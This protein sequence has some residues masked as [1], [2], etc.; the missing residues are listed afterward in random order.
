MIVLSL[1]LQ[2]SEGE[3]VTEKQLIKPQ[4]VFIRYSSETMD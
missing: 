3:S 1:L 4:R 2:D